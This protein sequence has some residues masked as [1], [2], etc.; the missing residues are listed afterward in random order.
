MKLNK[1][2]ILSVIML[3]FVAMNIIFNA[4]DFKN[5]FEDE[6]TRIYANA[7][8]GNNNKS[9]IGKETYLYPTEKQED[10]LK[11][12][13][14][15]STN[16]EEGK[17]VAVTDL[18]KNLV[19]EAIANVQV[20]ESI[21]KMPYEQDLDTVNNEIIPK[22][23]KFNGDCWIEVGYGD[24]HSEIGNETTVGKYGLITDKVV[25]SETCDVIYEDY[26]YHY[27]LNDLSY[28]VV[29]LKIEIDYLDFWDYGVLTSRSYLLLDANA[30]GIK[31]GQ[32]HTDEIQISF[33][34]TN[35][36]GEKVNVPILYD[37][38]DIDLMATIGL[39]KDDM[40]GLTT[41]YQ[42]PENLG[43]NSNEYDPL[44]S[45]QQADGTYQGDPLNDG[46]IF[47]YNA[48]Y[49][50]LFKSTPATNYTEKQKEYYSKYYKDNDRKKLFSTIKGFEDASGN[51][52]PD[53]RGWNRLKF[54]E[55][56][57]SLLIADTWGTN[58]SSSSE[59]VSGVIPHAMVSNG[60][61]G[62]VVVILN[63]NTTMTFNTSVAL[64]A[65]DSRGVNQKTVIRPYSFDGETIIEKTLSDEDDDG[66]TSLGEKLNYEIII[67]NPSPLEELN[68]VPIRDSLL[69]NTP[70]YLTFNNDIEITN[71]D[72]TS[73]DSSLY[74]GSLL[75]GT[76]A[77][78][79][80]DPFSK[81]IIKYS[82]T[83][84]DD[85]TTDKVVNLVSD[86][87]ENPIDYCEEGKQTT[88]CA[89]TII[90]IKPRTTIEKSV[91]DANENN[92]YEKDE[93]I[94]Y[95]IKVTNNAVIPATN[96]VVRDSL[97]EQE[98]LQFAIE[99]FNIFGT[100]FDPS[101]SGKLETKDF[102]ISQIPGKSSVIIKYSL[103][104]E[105]EQLTDAYIVNK[106][107][108]DGQDPDLCESISDDCGIATIPVASETKIVKEVIDENGNGTAE[109]GEELL[110]KIV[111]MNENTIPA[112]DVIVRD[113]LFE[114]GK[115]AFTVEDYNIMG[116]K[117]EPS[118]SGKFTSKDFTITE[119]PQKSNVI[120]TYKLKIDNNEYSLKNI[121][122]KVSDD[123]H[124]P[125]LCESIS[126]D[127]GIATI[128]VASE[129][130]IVKEVIDE[131]GNG[132][133]EIGEELLYKI[134]IMNENT[135]PAYDVVIRDSLLEDMP[136]NLQYLKKPEIFGQKFDVKTSGK[137]E[138]G[139][140]AIAKIP[141]KS[142]VIITYKL[143]LIDKQ[144]DEIINKATNNG[145]DPNLCEIISMT[146]SIAT[147]P[148][149]DEENTV[150]FIQINEDNLIE[151]NNKLKITP[152]MP[153]TGL[154]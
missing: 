56:E 134:V 90:P 47:D 54:K 85:L 91:S 110:Y 118:Y 29:D 96:V 140:L 137:L 84:N 128:P 126:D 13:N 127:C 144:T 43:F 67:T 21:M 116:T 83:L 112:Y 63:S 51:Y 86:N 81:I 37:F 133:A 74:S 113:S 78:T 135:I 60:K 38:S 94:T 46:S 53:E 62:S 124:D 30:R 88:D 50:Y 145:E 138:N 59:S 73:V 98:N 33:E 103:K 26:G 57:N 31:L 41:Y 152:K 117:F 45:I 120:I 93:V 130:K 39:M 16:D 99:E 68:E 123:G 32:K 49:N 122:N 4:M 136:S 58:A 129:T 22:K 77:L 14:E 5:N 11:T 101:S 15:L 72:G 102:K 108:D 89:S 66:V 82:M 36:A 52:T 109:I 76:F 61:D 146:C 40:Y 69:E 75:D 132:T 115:L 151:M 148:V 154:S 111:I 18:S 48:F 23:V 55:S 139:D 12:I 80:V 104:F 121:Q 131:N 20:K 25:E 34:F 65:E 8:K 70:K 153:H 141:A 125:N 42:N 71:Q 147:I 7:D 114:Q 92:V 6:N 19:D 10:E 9:Q 17:Y 100:K 95:E 24:G 44:W 79:R 87:G 27:N 142:E 119:I 149:K 143:K 106:V 64:L 35:K 107:T 2:V 1:M 28:E 3:L 105:N 97:F 150:E